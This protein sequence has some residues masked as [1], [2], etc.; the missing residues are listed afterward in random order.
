M[1]EGSFCR[2]L[3]ATQDQQL[4]RRMGNMSRD[5]TIEHWLRDAAS[6]DQI[7]ALAFQLLCI[8]RR[9]KTAGIHPAA[10]E[11]KAAWKRLNEMAARARARVA[12]LPTRTSA[13]ELYN[14]RSVG[15]PGCLDSDLFLPLSA[16][17][18]L[19]G[20]GYEQ[21]PVGVYEAPLLDGATY[22]IGGS[23]LGYTWVTRRGTDR[24]SKVPNCTLRG[25]QALGRLEPVEPQARRQAA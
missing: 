24:A 2:S 20:S 25:L 22:D 3:S 8:A 11:W 21:I 19:A 7:E 12:E 9:C 1:F 23:R 4:Q 10:R 18:N 17:L 5:E 13:P 16:R 6:P 14:R 15:K